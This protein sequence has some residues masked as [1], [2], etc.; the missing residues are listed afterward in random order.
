MLSLHNYAT[1]AFI[2]S[3]LGQKITLLG[4]MC[5]NQIWYRDQASNYRHGGTW[6]IHLTL[7][8]HIKTAERRIILH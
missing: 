8:G 5:L 4:D 2:M 6:Q 7:Y 1:Q 3:L